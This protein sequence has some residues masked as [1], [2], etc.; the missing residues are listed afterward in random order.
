L[1]LITT[2]EERSWEQGCEILFLGEWCKLY[3]RKNIWE[4]LKSQ[5]IPYHWDNRKKFQKDNL[6]LESIYEKYLLIVANELNR[7]HNT[8]HSLR[9]WRI[10]I[11]LWLRYFIDILYDKYL[12]IIN[13]NKLF[14]IDKTWIL[15]YSLNDWV[16]IN[17]Q[18][19][20]LDNRIDKWNHIMYAEI[21]KHIKC[22]PYKIIDIEIKPDRKNVF[23]NNPFSVKSI[24][25]KLIIEYNRL[26]PLKYNQIFF[27]NTI[28]P[29]KAVIDLQLA[30]G[31]APN[32][33]EL[34][35]APIKIER[36]PCNKKLRSK[37]NLIYGETEFER[38]LDTLVPSF[39]PISYLESYKQVVLD[40]QKIYPKKVNTI[41]TANAYSYDEAFKIWS[42]HQVEKS[43]KL[44][45]GQHGGRPG[46]KI[47]QSLIHQIK[48]SD[49]FISW[50]WSYHKKI[51]PLPSI[52]L[53]KLKMNPQP[54]GKV[55]VLLP[56]YQR[57]FYHSCS[58]PLVGQCLK[59]FQDQ[60]LVLKF[61]SDQISKN[62][63]FR[64]GPRG[65]AWDIE[66][67]LKDKGLADLIDNRS[68]LLIDSANES[69]LI[70]HTDNSTSLLETM[71]SNF[72]SLI[73]WNPE[74]YEL[75]DEA[76]PFFDAFYDVGIMHYTPESVAE[77]VNQIYFD[78]KSWWAQQKIQ[79]VREEFC[80]NFA[81]SSTDW[82]GA[83]KKCF[84]NI[85]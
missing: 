81:L 78:T 1:F 26:I 77:K 52:K 25:T 9:Y 32:I 60:L 67:R 35:V 56:S 11:G 83:W 43:A 14:T 63:N 41:F 82:L 76:K 39:M 68:Q 4:N 22:I 54:D 7:I 19:F 34:L 27:V 5:T 30:L 72:P 48:V 16:P 8:D 2:A 85:I 31:Q 69:R 10:V 53:S 29:K 84:A 3:N 47:I 62:Y 20:H 51:I 18:E 75:T 66:I 79:R 6:L 42:A 74:Y 38:L 13:A 28:W 37:F 55:L 57:Y 17:Y 46:S 36:K 64:L 61:L 12:S 21:I 24:I 50:G 71:A 45:I 59:H 40:G 70:I 33:F 58:M 73:Y 23:N 80:N 65:D 44:I 15:K 49:K